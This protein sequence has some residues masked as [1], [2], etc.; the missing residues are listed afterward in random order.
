MDIKNLYFESLKSNK[1][2]EIMHHPPKIIVKGKDI[3]FSERS[4][5]HKCARIL[6]KILRSFYASVIFYFVPFSVFYI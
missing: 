5:Y 3:K 4:C 2:K 1:L 6:Y